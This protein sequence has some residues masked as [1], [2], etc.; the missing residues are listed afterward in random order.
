[1]NRWKD[2]VTFLHSTTAQWSYL[3]RIYH[4]IRSWDYKIK[5]KIDAQGLKLSKIDAQGLKLDL[6][7]EYLH[8]KIP[9]PIMLNKMKTHIS[10]QTDQYHDNRARAAKWKVKA[11]H[12]MGRCPYAYH[13][14]VDDTTDDGSGKWICCVGMNGNER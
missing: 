8:K 10:H 14:A 12:D 1:M 9:G 5:S 11:T 13:K 6:T 2:R 3:V 4:M 7:N